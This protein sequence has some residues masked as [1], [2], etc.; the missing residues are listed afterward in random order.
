MTREPN[1]PDARDGLWPRV[2]RGDVED[3]T[4]HEDR[5]EDK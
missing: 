4:L 3:V 2:I 5:S 1:K